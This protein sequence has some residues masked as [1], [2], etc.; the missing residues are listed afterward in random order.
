MRFKHCKHGHQIT[1]F[2]T[3]YLFSALA[4]AEN[5][6]SWITVFHIYIS[7]IRPKNQPPSFFFNLSKLSYRLI[8]SSSTSLVVVT[9]CYSLIIK[10]IY[11]LL[12]L[13]IYT[14]A[15]TNTLTSVYHYKPLNNITPYL[16]VLSPFMVIST[17]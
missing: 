15:Y 2:S 9:L 11:Y 1:H 13:H 10:Y 12:F 17:K 6:S 7:P 16:L 3:E 8:L 4:I 14:Y 5:G